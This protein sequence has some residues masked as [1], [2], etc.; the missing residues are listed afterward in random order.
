MKTTP[1]LGRV[2]RFGVFEADLRAGELRK[3]GLKVKLQEKPFQILELLL[4]HPGEPITREE[5]EK[6]LWPDGTFVDF[7]HSLN[8][9]I[10]KL[11]E[12]LG[13]TAENPRFVE[14]LARRGYRFIYPVAP[15]SSPAEEAVTPVYD[16][17]PG[18][19]AHRA[20]LQKRLALAAVVLVAIVVAILA[21]NLAGLRERLFPS[22][23]P[24]IESIAVLPL[25]NLSGDPE[26]EYFADGMTEALITQLGQIRAL[27]VISRTSVM[28]YKL[29]R[30][31]LPEIARELNVDAVV[32]GSVLRSENRVRITA[33]L[34]HAPSDRH[35][36]AQSY[37]RDLRDVLS[38]QSEVASAIAGEIKANVTPEV[39]ARLATPRTVNPEAHELYLK[40]NHSL[41]RRDGYKATEYFE[42]AVQ[43][44]TNFARGYVGL[45]RSYLLLGDAVLL[46]SVQA[47]AKMKAAA[48]KALELDPSLAEAHTAL[49]EALVWDWD[50]AAA[51]RQYERALELN[52]NSAH[53]HNSYS[54]HLILMGRGEEALAYAKRAQEIDPLSRE[55]YFRLGWIY[56]FN[57]QYD[58]ALEHFQLE[59]DPWVNPHLFHAFAYREKG[60]Y[61]KAAEE[62][63]RTPEDPRAWGH[64]GNAYARAGNKAEAQKLLQKLIESSKQKLGTYEAALIYAG[65]GDKDR[66]FE[67]LQKAYQ[68]RDKGM[69]F[70]KVDPTLDPLRSD[71]RFQDLLRRMK[72]PD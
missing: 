58:K 26:Q 15:A 59:P 45:A 20:A 49:A 61:Q 19:A 71:P 54:I 32:E 47:A 5:I 46:P 12:A 10:N 62:F 9:A 72:F 53:T 35:L 2:I 33:N 65:L 50:W 39:Q 24:K 66:A 30:K 14:T 29:K 36:W 21:L 7:D 8:T 28:Q 42:Q 57:R 40:G 13:D 60:M 48:H 31:P 1:T 68:V 56:Y 25:E 23:P 43:K 37:E 52:P 51:E 3:N 64:L 18:D 44:D 17:R 4:E 16:R 69:T 22:P 70:L 41:G 6:K 63:L 67:W 55:R 34:L 11:R 38:L 27:R